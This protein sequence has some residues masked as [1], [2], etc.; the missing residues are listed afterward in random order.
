M[1]QFTTPVRKA[2]CKLRVKMKLVVLGLIFFVFI[3]GCE[4][5]QNMNECKI[6]E[7]QKFKY[8]P[9]IGDKLRVDV[10]CESKF[11]YEHEISNIEIEWYGKTL[12]IVNSDPYDVTKVKLTVYKGKCDVNQKPEKEIEYTIAN[13]NIFYSHDWSEE[14]KCHKPEK[15]EFWGIMNK[16]KLN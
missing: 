2:L 10:F 8:D 14:Y 16:D 9:S 5:Y 15:A 11:P 3:S 12:K 1:R 6:K 13:K 4:K 7:L